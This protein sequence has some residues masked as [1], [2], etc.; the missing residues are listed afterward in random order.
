M[1]ILDIKKRLHGIGIIPAIDIN[2]VEDAAPLANA[3]CNGGLP[4]AEVTFRTAIAHDA[5]VEMKKARPDL[6]VG[7]R[8]STRLNSSH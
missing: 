3:L 5:M 4:T 6:L 8:K 2:H 7:D 1:S